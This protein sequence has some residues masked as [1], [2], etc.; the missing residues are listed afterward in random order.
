MIV[1]TYS[2]GYHLSNN[3]EIEIFISFKDNGI[4]I[5]DLKCISNDR[6]LLCRF[7]KNV[8]DFVNELNVPVEL[9]VKDFRF[10]KLL[11]RQGFMIEQ[12]V[13]KRD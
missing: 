2:W 5:H 4:L 8:T 6:L 3:N 10:L 11:L 7:L 13:L 12:I 9:D 1:Q